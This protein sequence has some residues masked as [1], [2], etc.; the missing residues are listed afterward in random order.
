M[1]KISIEDM[2]K[3][4]FKKKEQS[5]TESGGDSSAAA[6]DTTLGSKFSLSGLKKNKAKAS[7]VEEEQTIESSPSPPRPSRSAG[8]GSS[9]E[10]NKKKSKAKPQPRQ[11]DY[12]DDDGGKS[13]SSECCTCKRML[14]TFCC[15][16][17]LTTIGIVTWRYGPWAK[18][19]ASV[20]TFAASNTCDG[21]CNGL[22]SNCD[23]PV[24]EV[25]FPMVHH[26]HSS[27][28]NN[29]VGASN[30]KGFEE[31]LVAGY[32]A[33]QLSTCMCEG[34]L[35]KV[36]L[37]RDEEWGLGNSNLGFCHKACGAGVRDPKAVL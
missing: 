1:I 6:A 4:N 24:N 32:R 20:T 8:A 5:E 9:K 7:V 10:S 26:A 14:G 22:K 36:L 23:L 19:S 34:F 3:F 12:E 37:S 35:S 28:D 29:F 13:S 27:Y 17:I 11:V 16:A 31:A 25:L 30:S 21:C 33:L 18:D 15:V 2:K